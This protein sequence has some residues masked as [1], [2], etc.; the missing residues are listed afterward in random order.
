MLLARLVYNMARFEPLF[1][2]KGSFVVLALM[3]RSFLSVR[4]FVV[5]IFLDMRDF[6]VLAIMSRRSS[7]SFQIRIDMM[8]LGVDVITM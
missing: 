3:V 1:G 8:V 6:D 7:M 2:R 4:Y 5:F